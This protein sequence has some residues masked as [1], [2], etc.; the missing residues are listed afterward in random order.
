MW[1]WYTFIEGSHNTGNFMPY[2]FR[3]VCGF[4]NVPR[5][6]EHSRVVRRGLRFIVSICRCN[7][8]CSTFSSVLLRP[9]VLVRPDPNSRLPAG[10]TV[11]QPTEPP[12][13]ACVLLLVTAK[14]DTWKRPMHWSTK[15]YVHADCKLPTT[16]LT[17]QRWITNILNC[18]KR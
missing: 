7:Y 15:C 13:H 6:C 1:T 12:V 14:K 11:A 2:S 4:S 9:W 8:K 18:S 17:T 3:I 10:Q 16:R 5:N